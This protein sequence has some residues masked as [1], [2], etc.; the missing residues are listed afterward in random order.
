MRG[1]KLPAGR[2]V[3]GGCA[4]K[5]PAVRHDASMKVGIATAAADRTDGRGG[6]GGCTAAISSVSKNAS[7]HRTG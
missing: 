6:F 2:V 5:G 1:A 7:C 3:S 4:R